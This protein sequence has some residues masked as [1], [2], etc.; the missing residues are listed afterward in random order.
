[1]EAEIA[2]P[3]TFAANPVRTSGPLVDML[4]GATMR[5]AAVVAETVFVRA[6]L[7][8]Y[9]ANP[10]RVSLLLVLLSEL[11]TLGAILLPR[12]AIRR[13]TSLI[14][15]ALIPPVYCYAFLLVVVP[16]YHPGR[17]IAATIVQGAGLVWI[18]ASKLTLGRAFGLLPA[19]RGLTTAGPYRVI[20]HPIYLGYLIVHIG[21]LMENP[22]LQNLVVLTLLYVV[23][24]LR[25]LREEALLSAREEYRA[26]CGQVR[27]R[28]I[29][30]IF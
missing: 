6:D 18:I 5:L 2:V 3:R 11:L 10:R 23:Q 7:A 17:E 30:C 28:M 26:Y 24:Y 13:D 4:A 20:R 25:I 1:M 12:T 15:L 22:V 14:A 9:I 8:A 21:F 27:F 19:D 29:P 16:S